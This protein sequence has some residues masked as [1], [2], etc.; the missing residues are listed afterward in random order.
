MID[1]ETLSE[2]SIR[3]FFVKRSFVVI[4]RVVSRDEYEAIRDRT[5]AFD[6]RTK[7]MLSAFIAGYLAAR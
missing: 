7:R 5:Y 4:G 2:E 6:G 1:P 3:S